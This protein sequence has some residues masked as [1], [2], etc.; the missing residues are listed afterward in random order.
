MGGH[1]L[2]GERVFYSAKD[3]HIF[4]ES[5]YFRNYLPLCVRDVPRVG[6]GSGFGTCMG[7]YSPRRVTIKLKSQT[8]TKGELPDI[9][10]TYPEIHSTRQH[11]CSRY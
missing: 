7:E 2:K 3:Q 11:P 8:L 6:P 9:K 1:Y 10:S 4:F 5:V